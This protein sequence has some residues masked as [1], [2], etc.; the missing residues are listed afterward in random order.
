MRNVVQGLDR[1][2]VK[3]FELLKETGFL[4]VQAREDTPDV[5][6][7]RTWWTS[8]KGRK[9]KSSRKSRAREP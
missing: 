4:V 1:I 9:A 8:G 7:V 2:P 5:E 3:D 6:D